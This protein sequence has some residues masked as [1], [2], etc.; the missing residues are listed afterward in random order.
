M[1]VISYIAKTPINLSLSTF[2]LF[3]RVRMS[4]RPEHIHLRES[5][6]NLKY[7]L[8]RNLLNTKGTQWL[9]FST[10]SPLRTIHVFQRFG[11]AWIPLK[12]SLLTESAATHAPPAFVG[13]ERLASHRLF[14]RSKDLKFTGDEIWRVRRMWKTL[15]RSI[16]DCCKSWT[17]S[18]GPSIVMLQQNTSTQKSASFG[19][20]CRTQM[21][22]YEICIRCTVHSVPPGH[23]VIQDYPSFI[24]KESQHKLSR[25]AWPGR[26]ESVT[27]LVP[28]MN[29]LV[30]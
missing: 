28:F 17:G 27:E 18:M 16:L 13:P 22:L 5:N 26:R 20:Y 10:Y 6:E 2:H 19:L 7:F 14:E 24:P 15:E 4:A 12:K 23:V 25:C 30:H 8:S 11:S 29:F 3:R 1:Q 21:I 9:H